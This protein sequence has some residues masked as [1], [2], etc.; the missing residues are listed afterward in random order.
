M[1]LALKMKNQ[2]SFTC[3]F[4]FNIFL[5]QETKHKF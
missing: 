3:H 5:A 4:P 1:E 2:F